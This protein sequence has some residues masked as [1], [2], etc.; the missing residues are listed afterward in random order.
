LDSNGSVE[1]ECAG[2]SGGDGEETG[3]GNGD[4]MVGETTGGGNGD[5]VVAADKED[6]AG[7]RASAIPGASKVAP[8]KNG[9][10]EEEIRRRMNLL[11]SIIFSSLGNRAEMETQ[12]EGRWEQRDRK[13]IFMGSLE[14]VSG[15]SKKIG[16]P[17]KFCQSS[18][19]GVT[20][21]VQILVATSWQPRN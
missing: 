4:R 20:I 9:R 12:C 7:P 14:G 16:S 13:Y 1:D 10:R 17:C 3:D 15:L 19:F 11:S 6:M 5:R 18:K 21:Y 8:A 2:E